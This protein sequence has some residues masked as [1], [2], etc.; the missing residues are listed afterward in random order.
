MG[1]LTT[2]AAVKLHL[3]ITDESDDA[4]LTQL[5]NQASDDIATR[6]N[7]TLTRET[8]TDET[9]DCTGGTRLYLDLYPIYSVASVTV[10]GETVTD[11]QTQSAGYL[12]RDDRWNGEVKVAYTGGYLLEP[13]TGPPAIARNLPYDLEYAVILWV[14][15]AY[16]SRGSEHLSSETIGPLK[17]D[18]WPEQ[19]AIKAIVNRYRRINV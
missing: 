6:C 11:Y 8:R 10:D 14:S 18:F 4:L 17:S 12:D 9:Y 2:L 13:I 19:P 5:I 16:N 7:R 15:G 1:A 3:G